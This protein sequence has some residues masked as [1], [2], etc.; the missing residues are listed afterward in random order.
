MTLSKNITAHLDGQIQPAPL[1]ATADAFML[2]Q[3]DGP[4][5]TPV[6]VWNSREWV[7][8]MYVTI[9]GVQRAHRSWQ[10]DRF[11][12][13]YVPPI[14]SYI[15]VDLTLDRALVDARAYV[16]ACW[17]RDRTGAGTMRNYYATLAPAI[18]QAG[19][20]ALRA[21]AMEERAREWV[22]DYSGH[23]PVTRLVTPE[24]HRAYAATATD[25]EAMHEARC[26]ARGLHPRAFPF[27]RPARAE[28]QQPE[29]R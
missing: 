23:S 15:F 12:P 13:S 10:R 25:R 19:D 17:L 5:V 26:R 28:S 4:D 14:G 9:D 22:S 16:D 8:P 18:A 24:L 1:Y 3:Y 29:A 21:F 20:D 7:T 27:Q 2:Y 11:D 6:V